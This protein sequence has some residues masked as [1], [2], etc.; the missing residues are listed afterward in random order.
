M[1]QVFAILAL[2]LAQAGWAL[3]FTDHYKLK[4]PEG[5]DVGMLIGLPD[6][7]LGHGKCSLAMTAG[8]DEL[9]LSPLG[10]AITQAKVGGQLDWDKREE[11]LVVRRAGM[12]MFKF[13]D[14][15]RILDGMDREIGKV[16]AGPAK[17]AK[18]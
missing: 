15:G 14:D 5:E 13:T 3:E 2:C 16:E 10:L 7:T 8:R 18:K 11:A 4:S 17:P 1:K 9:K 12:A 6:F